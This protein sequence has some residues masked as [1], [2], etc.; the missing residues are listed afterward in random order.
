MDDKDR[1]RIL[2][3][4]LAQML[5]PIREVPFSVIVKSLAGA[6]DNSNR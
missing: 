4:A 1:L 2:E 3:Q 5:K 6:S